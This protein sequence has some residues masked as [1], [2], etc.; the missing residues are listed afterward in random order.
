MM[1]IF[2]IAGFVLAGLSGCALSDQ[3]EFSRKCDAG[4]PY[5][6]GTTAATDETSANHARAQE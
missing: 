5:A 2:I 3:A 4:I 6:S 1:R